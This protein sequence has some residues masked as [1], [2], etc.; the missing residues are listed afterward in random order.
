MSITIRHGANGSYKSASAIDEY[1]IPAAKEGR[2]VVTNIRG[3]SRERTMLKLDDVPDSF[4]VIF[5]DTDT[6]EGRAHIAKWFHWVPLGALLLFDE[7][8]V[9]FPK[10]WSASDIKSLAYPGGVEAAGENGRPATWVEA[11]EMHRHY[12]WDIVLT[13]PNIKSVRDDI[14]ATTEGA[15]KHKNRAIFGPLFKGFNEGYHDATKNGVSQADFYYIRSKR[16]SS[17]AFELYDSTKTGVFK[18]TLNGFNL[19]LTPRVLVLL[20]AAVGA[21][22]YSFTAGGGGL[23]ALTSLDEAGE[24]AD[25]RPVDSASP[26]LSVPDSPTVQTPEALLLADLAARFDSAGGDVVD[27]SMPTAGTITAG[28]LAEHDAFIAGSV[29]L[30]DSYTYG[31]TFVGGDEPQTLT[32]QFLKELGY[33]LDDRGPCA[34][35]LDYQGQKS[36]LSCVAVAGK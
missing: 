34:L 21:F 18:N 27:F 19:F 12:N 1:F 22:S 25:Q 9:I 23:T 11:W 5:V 17:L 13:C 7:A 15:Y 35:L 8:G 26:D 16:C 10:L 2:T 14:R 24:L 20:A 4:D 6:A 3:V 33:T 28:P 32:S 30:G 36:L 29:R 31:V